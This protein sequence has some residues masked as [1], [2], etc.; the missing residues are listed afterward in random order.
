VSRTA[1]PDRLEVPADALGPVVA[2][3]DQLA[4]EGGGWINLFPEVEEQDV[5]RV[6][7]SAVTLLF[8][9]A[10]PPIPQA[11]IIAPTRGRRGGAPAQ[12]GV[13]HGVGTKILPGLTTAGVG[14]PDGWTLVQDHVRRGLVV[15]VDEGFAAEQVVA[16]AVEVATAVCPVPLTGGWLAEVHH[17]R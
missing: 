13:A 9:A 5:E 12:V 16:W 15:R 14:L 8:R 6:T 4:E 1:P 17:P 10:G 7:P 2:A 11:T 3:L